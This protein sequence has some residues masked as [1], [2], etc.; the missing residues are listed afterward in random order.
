[1]NSVGVRTHFPIEKMVKQIK[2]RFF[3][4]FTKISFNTLKLGG[5]TNDGRLSSGS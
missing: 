3:S 1:M 2:L 4:W 5:G